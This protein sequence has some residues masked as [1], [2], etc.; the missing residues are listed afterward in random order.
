MENVDR[1]TV[2]KGTI[3]GQSKLFTLKAAVMENVDRQTVD[4]GSIAGQSKLFTCMA[5]VKENVEGVQLT[6]SLP[7]DRG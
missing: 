2:D 1:Q 5:A 4:K 6:S 7:V 3:A